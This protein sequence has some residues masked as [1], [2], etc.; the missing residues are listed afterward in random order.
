MSCHKPARHVALWHTIVAAVYSILLS[1]MLLSK[2]LPSTSAS[3]APIIEKV[4]CMAGLWVCWHHQAQLWTCYQLKN[5]SAVPV[6]A[7][8]QAVSLYP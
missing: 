5:L 4:K 6:Y 1:M 8:A 3:A 2:I 7:F